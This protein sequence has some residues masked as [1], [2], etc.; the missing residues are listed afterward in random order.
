MGKVPWIPVK[1]N[2]IELPDIKFVKSLIDNY[3]KSRS[4]AAN[5]VEETKNLIFILKGYKGDNLEKF[6]SDINEKRALVLDADDEDD[7]SG[8][9]TLTP[10]MDITALR[11]HYEQLKRDIVDSGQGVIKDLDKFG[12][13]PSGVALKFMYSGLN[14]KADAM[15]MHV[16]FAF[17]DSVFHRFLPGCEA[18]RRNKHH[19]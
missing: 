3:D 15:V 2:D 7:N 6:L 9:T 16:T 8:V 19:V 17:E 12:N 11:E 18:H 14:L 10:T 5:S 13:A 4:E 1:N